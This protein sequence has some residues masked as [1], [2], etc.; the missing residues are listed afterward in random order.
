[1]I[2]TVLLVIALVCFLLAAANIPTRVN[3][4]ALG[5]AFWVLSLLIGGIG[6]HLGWR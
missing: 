3:L 2:G 1:M 5:L 6:G 4:I